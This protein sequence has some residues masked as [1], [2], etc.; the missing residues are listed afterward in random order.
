MNAP[1]IVALLGAAAWLSP[2]CT[3]QPKTQS[4]TPAKATATQAEQP[5]HVVLITVDTMRADSLVCTGAASRITPQICALAQQGR[6]YSKAISPAP[7][8]LPALTSIFTHSQVANEEPATV[9][10]HFEPLTTIADVLQS[11]GLQTAAFTD[12]HGLGHTPAS[13]VYPP[14]LLQRGFGVFENFGTDRR[15]I[16]AGQVPMPRLGSLLVKRN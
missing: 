1:R 6:L 2:A 11:R 14:T 16:G 7:A 9:V 15:G 3:P 4:P 10:A 8:T 13:P 5:Q 12:H